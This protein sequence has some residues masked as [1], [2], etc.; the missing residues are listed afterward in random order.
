MSSHVAQVNPESWCHYVTEDDSELWVLLL[1]IP[2]YM[3]YHVIYEV[4]GSNPKT[5]CTLSKHSMNW[6]YPSLH[7]NFTPASS[8]GK[9]KERPSW[10]WI[11]YENSDSGQKTWP[12]PAHRL[13]KS[14]EGSQSRL[15]RSHLARQVL[16]CSVSFLL[17]AP[18]P[19]HLA[20]A[21]LGSW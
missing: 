7:S 20:F 21:I 9:W 16:M 18:P 19:L 12:G 13:A 6:A 5:W 8:L 11:A 4:L 15:R 10:E 14:I 2:K 3:L 17:P 1:P